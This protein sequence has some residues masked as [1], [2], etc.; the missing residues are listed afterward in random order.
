MSKVSF[1]T[2]IKARTRDHLAP[3]VLGIG[4]VREKFAQ[5]ISMLPIEYG[6]SP[7][8]ARNGHTG[9]GKPAG[10]QCVVDAGRLRDASGAEIGWLD[11]VRGTGHV[12]VA[13]AGEEP[14]ERAAQ[15][16][17]E[18]ADAHP[19]GVQAKVLVLGEQAPDAL[20]GQAVL[21][22]QGEAHERFGLRHGGIVVVRPDQYLAAIHQGLAAAPAEATLQL[23]L[24]G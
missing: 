8:V 2:G 20:D 6:E 18:L 16:A 23:A 3:L 1:A 10:G 7:L 9:R 17:R 13:F 22:P 24:G 21:D 15:A 5:Q 4:A 12:V 14:V 11:V 19:G